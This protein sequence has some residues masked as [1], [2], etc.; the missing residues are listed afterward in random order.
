MLNP[1]IATIEPPFLFTIHLAARFAGD[2]LLE[3]LAEQG[4]GYSF[5]A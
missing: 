5:S 4:I 3:L 1:K 2:E